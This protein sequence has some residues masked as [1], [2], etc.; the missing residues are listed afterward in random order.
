L[1]ANRRSSKNHF[2][3]TD[4]A[5]LAFLALFLFGL[6]MLLFDGT[7][8]STDG[9]SMFAVAENLIKHGHVDTRQLENWENVKLGID[10]QPYSKYAL[11]PSLF[12]LPFIGL[13]LALPQL[14]ITQTTMLLM[15]LSNVL[16]AV[17]VY[18]IARRLGYSQKVA[19]VTTLLAGLATTVWPRIY[20]LVVEP[21]IFWGFAAT[22][23]YALAYR[24]DKKLIQAG[25]M[26][27]ALSITVL[28]KIVNAVTVPFFLWYL[29]AAEFN[30]LR[31]KVSQSFKKIEW[32]ALMMATGSVTLCLLLIGAYNF[33]RYGDPF[34]TGYEAGFTT[35]FWFGFIGLIVSPYKSLFLFTPILI[36]IP[37]TIKTMWHRHCHESMLI[38]GLLI[39]QMMVYGGWHAWGSGRDW[40]PRFF[41]PM[42]GLLLLLLLP[43]IEQ[44][45]QPKH[46]PKR[47]LW[48]GVLI[49]F[50]LISLLIQ[51]LGISARDYV[52][53]DAS[54]YWTRRYT[55]WSYI[56]EL[57]W[58]NP[59]QWPIWGHLLRFDPRRL[60]IIWH[61]E[62]VDMT[63]FDWP[64]LLAI[65]LMIGMGVAGIIML[66]QQKR[67]ARFWPV[68]SWLV[69]GGCIAVMLLRNYDD[70]R[71]IKRAEEAVTFWPDYRAL[72]TQLPKL[73]KP[74]DAVIF[75]DRRFELYLFNMDKSSAQRY[76]LSKPTQPRILKTVPKLLQNHAQQGRIWLVTDEL[77]NWQLAYAT[78]LWL[79][80]R[81]R[82]VEHHLF[83][84]SVQLT[85]FAPDSVSS[86][87]TRHPLAS[88]AAAIPPEPQ[89]AG[90]VRPDDYTFHRIASL[91]GW[92]WPDLAETNPPLLQAGQ[93]YD[94]ELYWVYRGKS[95]EDLFFVRLLNQA[96]EVV[97]EVFTTPRAD[98]RLIPGQLLIEDATLTL[99]ADLSPG[100][101]HLQIGFLIPVVEAGELTFPLPAE[102]TEVYIR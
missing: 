18:L 13:A 19:L 94:F 16:A 97:L 5:L 88:W 31:H 86:Y 39:I 4:K 92:H 6:Y 101:Y 36:L 90:L 25:L 9:L 56:G 38:L 78:E 58:D 75:T 70:P 100:N 41:V 79:M 102:M 96:G 33:F 55:L 71:S 93:T 12:M 74:E 44:T 59:D 24:Q 63:Y 32:P 73:V 8:H 47:N 77:D 10:G 91:L 17:Y 22:F 29:A 98:S 51:I 87:E 7:L 1:K 46:S 45:L 37:F 76:V 60:Q 95:P 15:P 11:G 54:W 69:A 28:H 89:L 53:L 64:S 82:P 50:G 68:A 61:W 30:P 81:G 14:G 26:S 52:F 67:I 80:E 65:L 20:D 27:L 84:R 57:S 83:G 42:T 2:I 43:F 23:Y 40:G 48:R 85:A 34:T 99:P 21:L 66:F 3:S 62:W 35:P 49:I 72:I